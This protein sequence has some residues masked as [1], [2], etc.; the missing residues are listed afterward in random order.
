MAALKFYNEKSNTQPSL[1]VIEKYLKRLWNLF[2]NKEQQCYSFSITILKLQSDSLWYTTYPEFF[3]CCRREPGTV[4]VQISE[5]GHDY[6]GR[7]SIIRH[8]R[9]A[10]VQRLQVV[11]LLRYHVKTFVTKLK[12]QQ[13]NKKEQFNK[14]AHSLMFIK[15]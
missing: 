12:K 13:T 2:A 9:L 1:K 10:K 11:E 15:I 4:E 5:I 3:V 14:S 6:Q 8:G 7:K